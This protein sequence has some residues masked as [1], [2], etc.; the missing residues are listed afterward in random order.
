MPFTSANF[1]QPINARQPVKS[2]YRSTSYAKMNRNSRQRLPSN[3]LRMVESRIQSQ[4]EKKTMD[5]PI[6][7]SGF[8]VVATT[9]TNEGIIPLNLIDQ[10]TDLQNRI[11]KKAFIKSVKLR[12]SGLCETIGSGTINNNTLRVC[13]VKDRQPEGVVPSF[14][15]IFSSVDQGGNV[16]SDVFDYQNPVEFQRFQHAFYVSKLLATYQCKTTC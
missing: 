14:E 1:W 9:N 11:G 13:V 4:K 3:A 5:L 16:T 2:T 6:D 7:P 10:G 12:I 15:T 8:L